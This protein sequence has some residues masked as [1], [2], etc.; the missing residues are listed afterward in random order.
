VDVQGCDDGYERVA[1]TAEGM[2]AYRKLVQWINEVIMGGSR[3][4]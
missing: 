4:Q 2:E 1:L 3:C